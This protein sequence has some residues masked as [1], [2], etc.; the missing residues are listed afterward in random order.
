V[1]TYKRLGKGQPDI[2]RLAYDWE[3]VK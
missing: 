3:A 2:I 1:I